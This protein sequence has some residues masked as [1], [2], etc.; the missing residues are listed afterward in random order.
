[1]KAF[2]LDDTRGEGGPVENN[3]F[4]PESQEKLDEIIARQERFIEMQS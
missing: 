1:M 4:R 2:F 3:S